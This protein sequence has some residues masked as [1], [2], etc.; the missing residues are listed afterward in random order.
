MAGKKRTGSASKKRKTA[1]KTKAEEEEEAEGA[2][3]ASASAPIGHAAGEE[4]AC[5]AAED[6]SLLRT[7]DSFLNL[8]EGDAS[9]SREPPAPTA[10]SA[11]G[12]QAGERAAEASGSLEHA[13]AE[14]LYDPEHDV[15]DAAARPA[16]AAPPP[17]EH[18]PGAGA[19]EGRA[20]EAGEGAGDGPAGDGE[21][22]EEAEPVADMLE[23]AEDLR[24]PSRRGGPSGGAQ[25]EPARDSDSER[26]RERERERHRAQG[27]GAPGD[28]RRRGSS[29]ERP[30]RR[31]PP[32]DDGRQGARFGR[33]RAPRPPPPPRSRSRD[34][35]RERRASPPRRETP[36]TAPPPAAPA[37]A[38]APVVPLGTLFAALG[39]AA[40]AGLV[41]ASAAGAAPP[42]AAPTGPEGLLK[43]LGQLLEP[44]AG[45]AGGQNVA[46]QHLTARLI[47]TI[48]AQKTGVDV[49]E[50]TAAL[51]KELTKQA[52]P[53]GPALPP[54]APAA[55]PA[56]GITPL[57]VPSSSSASLPHPA[58]APRT[59]HAAPQHPPP[60]ANPAPPP[61]PEEVEQRRERS[62]SP[63]PK[64]PPAEASAPLA[65]PAAP[66]AAAKVGGAKK[67][68]AGVP[69]Q[70]APAASAPQAAGPA[71]PGA[72]RIEP[73]V[74][75]PKQNRLNPVKVVAAGATAAPVANLAG[76][77]SSSGAP[78]PSRPAPAWKK[79]LEG[80]KEAP[81]AAPGAAA[82]KAAKVAPGVTVALV[83]GRRLVVANGE[84]AASS[85]SP[86]APAAPAAA[87]A[88]APPAKAGG[89]GLLRGAQ[90][91]VEEMEYEVE[92]EAEEEEELLEDEGYGLELGAAGA[93]PGGGGGD[94]RSIIA[95]RQ[96]EAASAAAASATAAAAAAAGGTVLMEPLRRARP[97]A[98]G[99]RQL[100]DPE[101]GEV[102]EVV[103]SPRLAAPRPAPLLYAPPPPPP[104]PRRRQAPRTAAGAGLVVTAGSKRRLEAWLAEAPFQPAP[105]PRRA[106]AAATF[107]GEEDEEEE[108]EEAEEE[109]DAGAE[110]RGQGA[111]VAVG[112][113]AEPLCEPEA[114]ARLLGQ[115]GPVL[116]VSDV[117]GY[118]LSVRPVQGPLRLSRAGLAAG[119]ELELPPRKFTPRE[120]WLGPPS[121]G[122]RLLNLAAGTGEA[123]VSRLLRP[124]GR[125]VAAEVAEGAPG[126]RPHALALMDS[127]DS[128]VRALVAL[129]GRRLPAGLL[130]VAFDASLQ[131]GPA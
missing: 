90:R 16:E 11:S 20:E 38:A 67:A 69:S 28:Y 73:I 93:A 57:P 52:A 36:A 113:L 84:A 24:R 110:G 115:Y 15:E 81:A 62:V 54:P 116:R 26:E 104:T 68:A 22:L 64:P 34:R 4:D 5:T 49:A 95:F 129:H 119:R 120:E 100:V 83:G 21:E 102:V 97:A 106:A 45:E 128:A 51:E 19:P 123:E 8:Q 33:E 75:A 10:P 125:V 98:G 87:A 58:S 127:E 124:Y 109:Q 40:A 27:Q 7:A 91:A 2:E 111:A 44:A 71:G 37:P 31:S 3:A 103:A 117:L 50:V 122:L 105:A 59:A 46:A 13:S 9:P 56:A 12:G 130:Y 41:A 65:K 61:A 70:Q 35:S 131:L 60:P 39:P 78:L 101:T 74:F 112:G 48:M 42:A 55:A 29:S 86:R 80:G 17:P 25:G 85:P 79:K 63:P 30:R 43:M 23:D 6:E 92:G 94:L 47:A 118:A 14:E 107:G 108:G 1:S 76:I 32:P 96:Q 72:A 114:L 88:R 121:A 77:R 82:P 89:F 53:A 66:Q 126:R 99:T 18:A